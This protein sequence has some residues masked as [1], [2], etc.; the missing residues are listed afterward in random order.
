MNLG[1]EMVPGQ[2][3]KTSPWDIGGSDA[4]GPLSLLTQGGF[5]PDPSIPP[6]PDPSGV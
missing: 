1:V 2:M 4:G 6:H 3:H 5:G